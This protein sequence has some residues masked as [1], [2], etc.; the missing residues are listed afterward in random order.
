M[1]EKADQFRNSLEKEI[2]RGLS[3]S[4]VYN[5]L[6]QSNDTIQIDGQNISV[7]SLLDE[8]DINSVKAFKNFIEKEYKLQIRNMQSKVLQLIRPLGVK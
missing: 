6:V 1:L 5:S 3:Y 8:F 4:E 7:K 2:K